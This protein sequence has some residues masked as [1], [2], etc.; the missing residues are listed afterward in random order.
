MQST[1]VLPGLGLVVMIGLG[2][3]TGAAVMTA[4][5]D[6]GGL[7]VPV[8]WGGV[9]I[10]AAL[11]L[12]WLT[13]RRLRAILWV[14][15]RLSQGELGATVANSGNGL[16]GRLER[17]I[18]AVSAK[19]TETHNAATTDLLTQVS[20]RG[21]ILSCL[22]TEVDRAVRH[23]RPLSVAFVD[24]DHFK[25]INDT[26]GHQVGDVVLRGVAGLFQAS[27]RQSDVVGRYGGEEFM[28]VLPETG[29]EEATLVAEKLRLLVQRHRFTASEGLALGVTISI[30]IAGGQG[31]SL[32]AESLVRDADQAMYSAKSLG[33]NQTYVFEEPNDDA[34]VPSA[35]I[36]SAGRARALQVA[37][38]ARQATEAALSEIIAPLPHY[39]GKPSQLIATV[40]VAIARDLALPEREVERI[41]VASL[42]HDIGK[43]AVPEQILEKPDALS[44][45]EWDFVKQHPRIGQVILDE[46]G[47]LL[48]AGKIILHHHERFGG[49]G[50]PHGLRGRDIPLGSR[51]VSIA[52]AYDAM[53]QD[54]PYK[55]AINHDEALVELRRH[56]GTQFD[57][58]LVD[59]FIRLFA[60]QPPVADLS[61]L[62]PRAIASERSRGTQRRASA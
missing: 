29:P 6:G 48:E 53:I 47:G 56:S 58:E 59:I 5:E 40:G 31:K 30:G 61:L 46:A 26:H 60:E 62:A 49:H 4:I 35:P 13:I 1:G 14:A 55:R 45:A 36:S 10:G 54:R 51:I 7:T 28:V 21:T 2:V 17:S 20:N 19:L 52:D 24:L 37:A 12:G 11:A 41:R 43:I 22:F 3:A 57:P 18:N 39:R 8:A 32:R 16:L 50:Y 44:T 23:G 42:L 27:L 15:E 9:A 34:R 38:I 33:R 25:V